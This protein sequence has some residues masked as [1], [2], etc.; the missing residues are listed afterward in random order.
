LAIVEP[1]GPR[2]CGHL[3]NKNRLGLYT[4]TSSRGFC[5]TWCTAKTSWTRTRDCIQA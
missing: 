2:K 3:R 1:I 4:V 5:C